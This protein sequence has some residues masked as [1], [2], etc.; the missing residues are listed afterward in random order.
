M[1][2]KWC[3]GI[4]TKKHVWADGLFTLSVK[5]DGVREFQPG[6]FLQIGHQASDEHVHRPYSV[7]SPW[8]ETLEFFVMIPGHHFNAILSLVTCGV[9]KGRESTTYYHQRGWVRCLRP[10]GMRA[11][12]LPLLSTALAPIRDT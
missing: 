6:Q 7:A 10:L 3:P 9:E 1:A 8:G 12:W 4:I 5:V 11:F 2:L